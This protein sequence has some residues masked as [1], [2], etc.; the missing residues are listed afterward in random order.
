MALPFPIEEEEKEV[1]L[2]KMKKKRQV[3]RVQIN[4][5]ILNLI[6]TLTHDEVE[7]ETE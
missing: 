5:M 6:L 3:H 2:K 4:E 7:E 1:N